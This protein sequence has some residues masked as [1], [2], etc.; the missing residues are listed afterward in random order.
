MM[1]GSGFGDDVLF[2]HQTA[3]VVGPERHR[4]LAD[5]QT[6]R[7]PAALN[8]RDVVQIQ[9]RD[10]LGLEVLEGTGRR[11]VRHVRVI[12]LERPRDERGEPAGFV[13][14]IADAA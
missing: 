5:L 14:Q 12:G 1:H 6:L 8:V 11:D 10:G 3:H 9:P 4:Q 13:L 7:H 2:D